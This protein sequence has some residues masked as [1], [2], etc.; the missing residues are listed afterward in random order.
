M[1]TVWSLVVLAVFVA[2][3]VALWWMARRT[4]RDTAFQ[5]SEGVKKNDEALRLGIALSSTN[6]LP[7]SH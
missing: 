3:G 6:T 1:T 2:G 5:Q 7:G 4:E